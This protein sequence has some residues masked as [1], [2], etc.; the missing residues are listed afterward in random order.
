[1]ELCSNELAWFESYM[2][3]RTRII[4]IDTVM[5]EAKPCLLEYLKELGPLLFIIFFND[6][7]EVLVY[8]QVIRYADD[9]A[10]L[11]SHSDLQTIIQSLNED[12]ENIFRILL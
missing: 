4:D 7:Q 2:F 11:F 10:I 1:M 6:F 8:S 9:T 5:S 3:L 12:L